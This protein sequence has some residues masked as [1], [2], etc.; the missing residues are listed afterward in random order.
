MW[1]LKSFLKVERAQASIEFILITGGVIVAALAIFSLQGTIGSF[2][3]VA[4]DWVEA[5]RNSTIT[6]ITR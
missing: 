2:A 6:K 5:E 3:D 4:T 1:G